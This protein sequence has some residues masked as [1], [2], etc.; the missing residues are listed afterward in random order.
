MSAIPEVKFDGYYN[1]E[2]ITDFLKTAETA[3][4]DLMNVRSLA[5][6]PEGRDIWLATLADP[7]T[8]PPEDK[9]A[10]HVQANVHAHE[11]GGTSAVLH[12][13]RSLLTSPEARELLADLTFYAVPRIN[14]DGAEYALST[15]SEIRSRAEIDEKINGI[16]PQDLNGDGMILNMRW[17]DR[18]GPLV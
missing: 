7:S 10:Y 1:H 12:L 16:I 15:L 8:G 5:Q 3:A 4:G 17:E 2:Q 9:P 13:L 18:T 6:T 14:P 11:V